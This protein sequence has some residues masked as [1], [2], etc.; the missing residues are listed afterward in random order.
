MPIYFNNSKVG[1]ALELKKLQEKT[2][3]ENNVTV[4][5]DPGYNGL[6]SVDVNIVTGDYNIDQIIDGDECE[7]VITTA[8]GKEIVLDLPEEFGE[9]R[10]V[11]SFQVDTDTILFSLD[12][13]VGI[14]KY[15]ISSNTW[16][17]YDNVV[18][19]SWSNFQMI[20]DDC[21]ISAWSTSGQGIYLYNSD[22]KDITR[23][24]TSGY[25][26]TNFQ[27][28]PA[29][30]LIG[31][32]TSYGGVLFYDPIAKTIQ[33]LYYDQH[34][35]TKFIYIDDV[36]LIGGVTILR[37]Y[38]DTNTIEQI[39]EGF[40]TSYYYSIGKKCLF[41]SS[42]SSEL[43]VL[44]YD[45]TTNSFEKIFD[46]GYGY[47]N[48]I[49]ANNEVFISSASSPQGLYVY[50]VDT[51][52]VKFIIDRFYGW[53]YYFIIDDDR[54]LLSSS[55][56]NVGLWL[57]TKSANTIEQVST[58]YS[59]WKFF[60]RIGD[61]ILIGGTSYG[62]IAYNVTTKTAQHKYT[63]NGKDWSIFKTD[64]SNCYIS[65]PSQNGILYY[66]SSDNTIKFVQ[67]KIEV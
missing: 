8:D 24:Y 52:D 34:S 47:Q 30:W 43:G 3:T 12:Q 21:L 5:P 56:S 1:A 17:K 23:I 54:V 41:S 57:Y 26:W 39:Y 62:V 51:D 58:A 7:L 37:Y 35:R 19:S 28:V 67:Y 22:T 11:F 6:S 42:K 44:L 61:V 32:G 27:K 50:N 59:D 31:C 36:L 46:T 53:K 18:G 4:T 16:T 15:L 2:V 49:S 9:A 45:S 64:G 66:N 48:F 60:K 40:Q 10:Q 55:S 25:S 13:V 14:W 38:P 29:G 65:S 33:R 63:H 20:G